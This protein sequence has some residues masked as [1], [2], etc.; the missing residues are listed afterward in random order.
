MISEVCLTSH[1]VGY[2]FP[3]D[4]VSVPVL[5]HFDHWSLVW[6]LAWQARVE[7][8]WLQPWLDLLIV[9]IFLICG[10][11]AKRPFLDQDRVVALLRHWHAAFCDANI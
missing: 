8:I 9:L 3:F 7:R 10:Q 5:Q 2:G 4:S 6:V 11:K 1:A